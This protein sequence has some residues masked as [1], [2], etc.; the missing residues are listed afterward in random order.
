M[1]GGANEIKK[2]HFPFGYDIHQSG[3]L[4]NGYITTPHKRGTERMV[5]RLIFLALGTYNIQYPKNNYW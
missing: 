4:K 1:T 5:P 3:G 2:Q